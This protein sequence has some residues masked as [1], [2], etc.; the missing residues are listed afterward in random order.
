VSLRLR[1]ARPEDAPALGAI[2]SDWIDETDWMPRLHSRD[3]DHGFAARLI[4][5]MQVM[6]AEARGQPV[7]FLA[8]REHFVHALYLSAAARGRGIGR[9]LLA[10]AQDVADELTL[11]T[12][13]A[14]HAAREFYA[15]LGFREV[16]TGDGAGNDEGLP[17]VRLAWRRD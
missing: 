7:G 10:A 16:E 13:Q 12:F 3:E 5:E 8:R 1:P 15:A 14:N 4:A 6:V 2:L 17:D 9:R 11:W